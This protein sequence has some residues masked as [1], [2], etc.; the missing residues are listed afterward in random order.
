M[1][2]EPLLPLAQVANARAHGDD[3]SLIEAKQRAKRNRQLARKERVKAENRLLVLALCFVIGFGAVAVKMG[4]VATSGVDDDQVITQATKIVNNRAD[5][6]DRSGN[7]LATN[8]PTRALYAQPP[9][10]IDPE[11]AAKE[12]VK[13]FPDL[14]PKRITKDFIGGKRKFIWVKKSI[15][16]EQAQRVHDLGEPGLLF[17][18]RE[19]RIFPNGKLAA[20]ILGGTRFGEEGTRAAEVVGVAGVEAYFD[21]Y[22][23]NPAHEGAPLQ[24][25]ID[26][27]A[28]AV[29]E[30]VLE[31]G[32]I[33]MN[34]K[35]ASAIMMDVHSGEIMAMASLPDFDP[36][37]RPR[38]LTQGDRGDDPLFNRAVQGL[39]ELGSTFKIFAVG[40]ALEKGLVTR[41]SEVNTTTPMKVGKFKIEDFHDNGPSLTVE[42]VIMKSSNTGTARLAVQAGTTAQRRILKDLGFFEPTEIELVEGPTAKP[43]RPDPWREINTITISYGHG[44]SASPLHLAT[45]YAMIANGGRKVVPT[46][47]RLDITESLGDRVMSETVA[48]ELVRMLRR[49]VGDEEGTATMAEV[50][51]YDVAGKTGTAEKAVRGGYKEDAVISTFASIFPASDPRYVLVVSLDEPKIQA[52]GKER[53]TAGWTA[54][55]VAGEIITRVAPIL[56]LRPIARDGKTEYIQT[57]N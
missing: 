2:R 53:R 33:F 14:D 8:F 28:Q 22:L 42:D 13:I 25:S 50:A 44:L 20:H 4:M 7:I 12:I 57:S 10:M 27:S 36:N 16:P 15:S 46:L 11:R 49:V 40:S 48:Q 31:D 17:A 39:Y 37:K 38:P 26:L 18:N 3:I 6:I 23:R 19:M 54:A 45:A 35:G 1:R 47:R 21:D 52:L 9:L 24:L 56:G 30:D 43:Q 41:A 29:L 51:G 32:M 55:P 5:I 34:S